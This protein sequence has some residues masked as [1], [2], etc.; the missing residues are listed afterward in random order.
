[1]RHRKY[2]LRHGISRYP[3]ATRQLDLP[4]LLGTDRH[5]TQGA[6]ELENVG[7]DPAMREL[8]GTALGGLGTSWNMTV[9]DPTGDLTKLRFDFVTA[10]RVEW[11][12]PLE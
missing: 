6:V 3:R 11:P 8:S 5:Y 9:H 10:E 1:M 2:G 4:H 7:W 12:L